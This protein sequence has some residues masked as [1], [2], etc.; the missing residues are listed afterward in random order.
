MPKYLT[1]SV[2]HC[3]GNSGV[4]GT[5][6]GVSGNISDLVQLTC[7]PAMSP[8]LTTSCRTADKLDSGSYIHSN[9]SSAYVEI[10]S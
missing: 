6:A 9:V 2:V 8:N 3:S 5:V 4:K 7:K 10:T 1:G